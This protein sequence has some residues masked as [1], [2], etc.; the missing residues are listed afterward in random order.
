MKEYLKD[1]HEIAKALNFG[2]YPVL[3]VDLDNKPFE[4]N[5]SD[6]TEGCKCRV[7]WDRKG[8]YEGM[9]SRCKLV[10]EDGK[11]LLTGGGAC[12]TADFAM[13]DFL[14]LIENANKPL[15]HKGQIVAVAHYS[16]K[17]G[18]RFVR[19]MKVSDKMDIHCTTVTTLEPISEED[20]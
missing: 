9:S 14:D 17:S 4:S 15:V 10:I 8:E 1:R 19:M 7:A 5:D 13:S 20:D 6:F 3:S 11:Y 18:V 2:K 16:R 12:L